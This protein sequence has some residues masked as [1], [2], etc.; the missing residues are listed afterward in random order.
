MEDNKIDYATLDYSAFREGIRKAIRQVL[1]EKD[2]AEIDAEAQEMDARV[3]Q[4]D[5]QIKAL[6]K[7]AGILKQ[8]AQQVKQQKPDETGA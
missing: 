8:K 2:K 4:T 5:A 1:N 6:Q 3:K 7:K